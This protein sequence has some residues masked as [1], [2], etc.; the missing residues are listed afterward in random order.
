MYLEIFLERFDK[1]TAKHTGKMDN[2][3]LEQER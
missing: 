2:F 1:P 3:M